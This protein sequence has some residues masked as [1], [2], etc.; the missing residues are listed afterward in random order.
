MKSVHRIASIVFTALALAVAVP[1]AAVPAATPVLGSEGEVYRLSEAVDAAGDPALVLV[2]ER[3]DGATERL[4]VP[5]TEGR[6]VENSP[7]LVY[8]HASRTL[9]VTWEERLNYIHS[10]IHLV[11]LRD[12][13]WTD[14][15]EV[16]EGSFGFK[17]EPRL[18]ATQDSYV[19]ALPDGGT[20]TVA[21]TV[22]HVVWVEERSEGQLVA[23]A[24]VTLL[25]GAY[26][27]QRKIF[28]LSTMVGVTEPVPTDLWQSAAPMVAPAD[29][30]HS[31]NVAFVHPASGRLASLRITLLP[32][33]LSRMADEL[34]NHLIDVGVRHDWQSPEGLVRLAEALR[35]HLIDVGFRLDPQIL[36][37]VADGL[38]NH[39]IDVGVQYPPADLVRM[40]RDLRNHLI[41]VGF[42]LDDRG[43]RRVA[44]GTA[45]H[46]VLEVAAVADGN[47]QALTGQVARVTPVDDWSRPD[48]ASGDSTLLVSRSGQA[49]LL[50]WTDGKAVF[51][52]ET[53]G[54]EW[55]PVVRLPL[56][57]TLDAEQAASLLQNRIRNR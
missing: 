39:L 33:E 28:D 31:V 16:S 6:G 47:E 45:S 7:Y 4:A 23:Y 15:I 14:V 51:Y 5:A 21:R 3:P 52:R 8:E 1:A 22:L 12:G 36:R 32:G 24:P 40:A 10:L 48:E 46:S 27:G 56:G 17:G 42:R 26:I 29:D 2:I 19:V 13:E 30:D 38:R 37:H 50:S 35:N 25:D 18:A 53:F 20:R 34:R 44:A 49:A 11:G 55:S 54:D 43:L 9:F 57:E 41:D